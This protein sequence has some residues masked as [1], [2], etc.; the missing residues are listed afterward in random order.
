M[1]CKMC[2]ELVTCL[3]PA[4]EKAENVSHA[5]NSALHKKVQVFL[6]AQSILWHRLKIFCHGN[7]I[8]QN[9][10][11]KEEVCVQFCIVKLAVRKH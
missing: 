5:M 8:C 1:S 2:N 6:Q 4:S 7:I 3:Q 10:C 11:Y 9:K